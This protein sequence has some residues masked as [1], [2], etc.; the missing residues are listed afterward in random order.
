MCGENFPIFIS[1]CFGIA[2]WLFRT[3]GSLPML[4][5]QVAIVDSSHSYL[6]KALLSLGPT[7]LYSRICPPLGGKSTPR[8]HSPSPV[9]C[10]EYHIGLPIAKPNKTK[11]FFIS[12]QGIFKYLLLPVISLGRECWDARL[13]VQLSSWYWS[14]SPA[15]SEC[16]IGRAPGVIPWAPAQLQLLREAQHGLQPI[17]L[18]SEEDKSGLKSA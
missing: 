10:C 3:H 17:P 7:Q 13:R 18:S 9:F 5:L 11:V 8:S 1:L 4:H 12:Q 16:G 2:W 6:A 15:L 14:H